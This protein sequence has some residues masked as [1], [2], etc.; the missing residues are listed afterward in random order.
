MRGLMVDSVTTFTRYFRFYATYTGHRIFTLVA[1]TL[2]GGYAEAF[3]IALFLPLFS[4]DGDT[5]QPISRALAP[6]VQALGLPAGPVGTLPLIVSAFAL[7]GLFLFFG[8]A[9]QYRLSSD[10]TRRL[11]ERIVSA[12]GRVD[13]ACLLSTNAGHLTNVITAEV[14]RTTSS[15]VYYSKVFPRLINIG[16]FFTII[17]ALQW[18]LT[19]LVVVAGAAAMLVVRVPAA[20]SHRESRAISGENGALSALLIQAVQGAKYLLATAGFGQPERKIVSSA[21]TLARAEYR[22]GALYS[23]SIALAQPLVVVLLAC[24]LYYHAVI[25]RQSL[26]P[27]FVLMMYLYRILSEIFALQTEWQTFRSFTGGLET[28]DRTVRQ[29]EENQELSGGEQYDGLQ[30]RIELRDVSF[31]YDSARVVLAHVDVRADRNRTVALVGESGAGKSTLVD[32]LTG[33]LKPQGGGVFI[34][35]RDLAAIDKAQYRRRL[36]YVPQE[37]VLFDDTVANNICLWSGDP[38]CPDFMARIR[39]AARKAHCEEF[40][41]AMPDRYASR[42]GDRGVKLSGGQRQRLA[43]AREL[44]KMPEILILDEATSALDSESETFIQQSIES[45]KGKITIIIIAHRL[46]TIRNCDHLYLLEGGRVV[47]EGGFSELLGRPSS[48][49][50]RV[51]QMQN[52]S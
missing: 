15:F 35:G 16:I 30:E 12:V 2:V 21:R 42:I 41:E 19:L 24:V 38:T 14:G 36:G 31:A 22:I 5:T 10:I 4:P 46:S 50:R 6:A 44:F 45:L 17:L 23:L 18:R 47:E 49:F 48:R 43:I 32:L 39:E 20:L 11:R 25:L 13:Y 34:D 52:L 28:V 26:A 3:G 33:I 29:M 7:K 1:I 9:Y 51:C 37:A 40:I 8:G 27:A